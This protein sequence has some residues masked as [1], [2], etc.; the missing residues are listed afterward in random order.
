VEVSDDRPLSESDYKEFHRRVQEMALAAYPNPGRIGCPGRRALEEVASLPL[1]SRHPL[2]QEHIS[3]CSPCLMELLEIR[4]RNYSRKQAAKKKVCV[5]VG[6]I[7][8]LS[9]ISGF[10]LARRSGVFSR[11]DR[12]Q[13]S[14]VRPLESI[15]P[16][17]EPPTVSLLL[18]PGLSRSAEPDGVQT[19]QLPAQPSTIKLSLR[20]RESDLALRYDAII[21]REDGREIRRFRELQSRTNPDGSSIV[22]FKIPSDALRPGLYIVV[23]LRRESN[24]K[25][26]ID[27]AYSL[28][29]IR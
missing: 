18:E 12:N 25:A 14:P 5:A 23:L 9:L 26:R 15:R 6:S 13:A 10:F 24:G 19:L 2:F 16:S 3:R 11:N 20:V 7:L 8:A 28:D 1:S 29:A 4:D 17:A 27:H 21:N 22:E